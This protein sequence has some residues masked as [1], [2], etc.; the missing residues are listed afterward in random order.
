VPPTDRVAGHHRH[1]GLRV[2]ADVDLEIEDVEP[3]DPLVVDV[4][5]VASD[6]LVA[7]L[8]KAS[9]PWPVMITA[10]TSG[11]SRATPNARIISRVVRGRNALRT[12]GRSI[13]IFAMPS[14]TSY[15]MS[16]HSPPGLPVERGADLHHVT[17]HS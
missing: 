11:S 4:A 6:L 13:V 1:D 3:A 2:P 16:D 12:S 14:A 10:P 8:Q 15:R 7:P 17:S 9:D 5:V